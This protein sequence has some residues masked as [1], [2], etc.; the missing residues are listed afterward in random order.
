MAV[1]AAGGGLLIAAAGAV[2][3]YA[4]APAA[5]VAPHG[6]HTIAITA[7]HTAQAAS[8]IGP[9]DILPCAQKPGATPADTCGGETVTCTLSAGQPSVDFTSGQVRANALVQCTDEVDSITLTE[10]LLQGGISVS[11]DSVTEPH[12]PVALT[13]VATTCQIGTYIN[14]VDATITAPSGYVLRG[15]SRPHFESAPLQVL[16]TGCVPGGG[17]GGGGGGGCAIHAPS[18]AGHP[19]GRHPDLITC[20]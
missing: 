1:A 17:G 5:P 16:P 15:P 18:L 7:H 12:S 6:V 9:H 20:R 19:A 10:H 11:T 14:V 3:A 4:S 2:P 8:G 13:Q